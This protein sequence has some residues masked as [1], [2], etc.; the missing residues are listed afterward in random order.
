ME[1]T[2]Y[3]RCRKEDVNIIEEIKGEAISTY[4]NLIVTE[5]LRF[6]GKDPKSIPCKIH[7]DSKNLE[8]IEENPSSGKI[9]GLVLYAKKGRIVCS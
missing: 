4:Q 7:I 5:I 3:I 1:H 6:K 9:G 2:V 8:S